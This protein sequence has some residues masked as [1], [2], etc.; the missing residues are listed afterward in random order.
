[1]VIQPTMLQF[2]ERNRL[3]AESGLSP[4]LQLPVDPRRHLPGGLL[5]GADPRPVSAPVLVVSEI[6]D[7]AAEI[8]ADTTDAERRSDCHCLT[9]QRIPPPQNATNGNL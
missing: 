2:F 9:F 6:S 8:A 5:I 3:E 1:M 7:S 4:V